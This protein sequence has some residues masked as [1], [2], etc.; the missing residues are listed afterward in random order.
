MA[1]FR[2]FEYRRPDISIVKETFSAALKELT[3]AE[4]VERQYEAIR[5]INAMRKEIESMSALGRIRH[6]I[7]TIDPFYEA[8]NAFYDENDP[9]FLEMITQYYQALIG[10]KYRSELEQKMGK[11]VFDL[12]EITLKSFKPEIIADMQEENALRTEYTKL[13][14]SAKIQFEGEE[15]NLSQ[16]R[17]FFQAHDRSLRKRAY[18]AHTH[19]FAENQKTLDTLFDQLVKVRTHMANKL[20]FR[21]FVPLGYL[22]LNRSDYDHT[23]V[24]NFRKQVEKDLVPVV[25]GLI[26]RQRKRLGLP[27]MKYYDERLKFLSG[28][29]KPKGDANWIVEQAKQM[30][31]ELSPET[32]TFFTFMADHDLFDLVSKKGKAAGGYCSFIAEHRAPFIFSNFNGT[33]GDVE[34]LTHEAGHA[35]QT[36]CSAHFEVPEYLYP[37]YEACEI[38]SMSMEFFTYPWMKLFFLEEEAKFRFTHLTEALEFIPYGVSVDEFQHFVYENPE[39]TPEERNTAWRRIEN[40]YLPLRDYDD[41]TFLNTGTW[42][43]RQGHIFD[44]PFYYIDYTLAGICAFQFWLKM[45]RDRGRAWQDYLHLCQLGGSQSFLSL[46]AEAGLKN[47]FEDG[48]VASVVSF[49]NEQLNAIDDSKF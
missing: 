45:N 9:I 40:K 23:R 25:S 13:I 19:F 38:H 41:N 3:E 10:S 20:G 47:P 14:A 28:N 8:E 16:M 21:N 42:W 7:D 5:N 34:V 6:T 36:Y 18:E 46:V 11:H 12:A 2:E 30:Y 49:I 4:N 17:A 22:K 27:E 26:E 24:A 35:F 39:A 37:T 43:Y 15:R 48:S 33:S 32:H 29:A 1:K 44:V 31:R